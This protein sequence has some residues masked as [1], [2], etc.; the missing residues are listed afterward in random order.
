MGSTT[1]SDEGGGAPTLAAV[2]GKDL[3]TQ[4]RK[5]SVQLGRR[6]RG[7]WRSVAEE[8]LS[9]CFQIF[10]FNHPEPVCGGEVLLSTTNSPN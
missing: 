2:C 3:A 9:V 4:S 7:R 8:E 1:T 6:S 5:G 10:D